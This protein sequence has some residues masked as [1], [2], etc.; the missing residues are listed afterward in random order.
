MLDIEMN[1]LGFLLKAKL[2]SRKKKGRLNI[3]D[4]IVNERPNKV[5]QNAIL[6]I[7]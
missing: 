1:L 7:S 5:K 6:N 4:L 2:A 3:C